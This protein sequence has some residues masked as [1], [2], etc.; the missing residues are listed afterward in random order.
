MRYL[1]PS[2]LYCLYN[3]LAFVNLASY[4]PTSYYLL[5]QFHVVGTGITFQIIFSKRLSCFQWLSLILLTFGCV[6]KEIAPSTTFSLDKFFNFNLLLVF[7]QVVASCFASVYNEYLLK[8]TE[9]NNLHIMI[10]NVAM[11][12]DAIVCNFVLLFICSYFKISSNSFGKTF[13]YDSLNQVLQPK[14]IFIILNNALIGICTSLFLKSLN[15][16]FKVF[17]SAL[18]LLLVALF[19]WLILDI[20]LDKFTIISIAIVSFSI[21]LYTRNP[22]QNLAKS[23]TK[24]ATD[25]LTPLM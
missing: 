10:Q 24:N 13:S 11:Y 12:G 14:V 1:T 16:I 9:K 20:P 4:D 2:F 5:L 21:W 7:I 18:E 3:N 22:V 15:S 19:S 17:A 6:F 8:D 23:I 25:D